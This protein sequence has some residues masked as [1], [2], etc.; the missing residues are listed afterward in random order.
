MSGINGFCP[1]GFVR[2]NNGGIVLSVGFGG[3]LE[4]FSLIVSARICSGWVEKEGRANWTCGVDSERCGVNP[5]VGI[6]SVVVDVDGN[7]GTM[8]FAGGRGVF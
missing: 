7:A 6:V 8:C 3:S 1:C 2:V 4:V 5:V